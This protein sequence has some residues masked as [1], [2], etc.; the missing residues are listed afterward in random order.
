VTGPPHARTISLRLRDSLVARGTVTVSDGSPRAD[1]VQVEGP[2]E[3]LRSLEDGQE[4]TTSSTRTYRTHLGTGTA[5]TAP[6]PDG[7]EGHG[8]LRQ[9]G[10]ADTEA[11]APGAAA[12]AAEAR[13]PAPFRGLVPYL[14]PFS[15]FGPS[16]SSAG[17]ALRIGCRRV[18]VTS[19]APNTTAELPVGEQKY[20]PSRRTRVLNRPPRACL[21]GPASPPG[22]R[23]A[24]RSIWRA[25]G[26]G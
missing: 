14:R 10:V 22:R 11:L 1:S 25:I 24:G 9:G 16:L 6:S 3:G 23:I 13:G 8:H 26:C 20:A 7:G 21:P 17:V 2:E 18:D 4:H 12:E 5:G 15:F 19:S